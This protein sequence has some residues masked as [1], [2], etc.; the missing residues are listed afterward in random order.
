[1][2]WESR[3]GLPDFH[4]KW[5]GI[6]LP[7]WS[8][9]RLFATGTILAGSDLF[10]TKP[11][12]IRLYSYKYHSTHPT[13]SCLSQ[14]LPARTQCPHGRPMPRLLDFGLLFPSRYRCRLSGIVLELVLDWSF[15]LLWKGKI[16][17]SKISNFAWTHS[18][19]HICRVQNSITSR[20]DSGTRLFRGLGL[21]NRGAWH[22]EL[23]SFRT[24]VR[25]RVF[26]SLRFLSVRREKTSTQFTLR[27][28]V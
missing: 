10:S 8:L 27:N 16:S 22:F 13:A 28:W 23:L 14:C 21:L 9:A 24:W 4:Q 18:Y 17:F 2:P 25:C 7:G 6:I 20:F 3:V 19:M 15:G 12:L 26:L 1:M 5:C 11:Q